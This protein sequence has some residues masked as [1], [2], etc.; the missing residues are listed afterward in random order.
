MGVT[1]GVVNSLRRR[2]LIGKRNRSGK[3]S[4]QI[5]QSRQQEVKE[6]GGGRGEALLGGLRDTN[7]KL[8]QGYE[9]K[10]KISWDKIVSGS[11]RENIR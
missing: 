8:E 2:S 4:Q 11:L 10:K 1:K 6:D 5:S 3:Q 7:V 9:V